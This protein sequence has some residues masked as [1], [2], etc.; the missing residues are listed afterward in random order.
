MEH[1]R[2][3]LRRRSRRR[4]RPLRRQLSRLQDRR[5]PCCGTPSRAIGPTAARPSSTAC[6]IGCFATTAT[7]RSPTSRTRRESP[8][9]KVSAWCS[10]F[11][12]TATPTSTSPTICTEFPLSQQRRRHL[13]GRRLWRGR[14][15]RRRRQ[16]PGRHGR[17]L[18]RRRRRRVSRHLRD[19]LRGRAQQPLQEPGRRPVPGRRGDR[20][21]G[22]ASCR[23]GSGPSSS[24]TTTTAIST[25]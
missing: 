7:A 10:D 5:D 6:R 2:R 15:L 16:G 18:C 4:P 9:R 20:R 11:D 21:L 22:R 8:T 23:S 13:Q 14:R 1:E 12:R 17:R 3:V 25:S 19:E 24:T